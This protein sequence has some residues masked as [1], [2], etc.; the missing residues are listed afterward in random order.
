MKCHKLGSFEYV[1]LLF[2]VFV[3]NYVKELLG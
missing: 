2:V 1:R 3:L